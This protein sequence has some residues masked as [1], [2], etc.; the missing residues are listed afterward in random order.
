MRP[1]RSEPVVLGQVGPKEASGFTSNTEVE[2]LTSTMGERW[3]YRSR[4]VGASEYKDR[5]PAYEYPKVAFHL[6]FCD[7][8][9]GEV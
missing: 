8:F 6:P 5:F 1:A 9:Q 7:R 3:N 2:P 4:P